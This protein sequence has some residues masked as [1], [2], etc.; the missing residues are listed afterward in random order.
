MNEKEII[1]KRISEV[2]QSK[3]IK[4]TELAAKLGY[5][6]QYLSAIELGKS[7]APKMSIRRIANILDCDEKYLTDINCLIPNEKN[8]KYEFYIN[9]DS[10]TQKVLEMVHMAAIINGYKDDINKNNS[11]KVT[12]VK[13]NK[14]ISIDKDFLANFCLTFAKNLE[15]CLEGFGEV[16]EI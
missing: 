7:K 1:G 15:N 16:K 14:Q 12:F 11:E 8:Y 3:G 13:H 4:Q 5:S 9:M 10:D 6:R 2:R